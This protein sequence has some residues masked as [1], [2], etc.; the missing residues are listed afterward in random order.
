MNR[1]ARLKK[2]Y[3]AEQRFKLYGAIS[4]LTALFFVG[5]LLFKVFSG[6]ATAFIKTTIAV[7]VDYSR[8][9]LGFETSQTPSIDDLKQADFYNVTYQAATSFYKFSNDAEEKFIRAL[10][11]ARYEREIKNYLFNNP[12]VLGK[13]E[14]LYLTTSDDVDQL[15]KGNFPR[16]IPEERRRINNFQLQVYDALVEQGKIKTKFNNYFFTNGDSRDSEVAGIAGSMVGSFFSIIICLILAFPIAI[17]AAVYLEEFAP[18]NR[19]TEIIEINVNNLA[20]V[21]SIVFGLLALGILLNTFGLPRSTSLV[22]GIT[23]SLMTLPTIIIA[24]RASLKAVPPSIREAALAVGASKVQTTFHHVVPLAMPGTLSGTII[25]LAQALGET[26]PLL[27]IGMV[28]FVVDVP[29]VPTDPSAS[30]PVQI[31]LWSEQAE[32]GFVEKTS[33]TIMLLIGFLIIM[34]SLA[35]WAR[36][37]FERKWM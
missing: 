16:D 21:P 13:K 4:I 36:Q 33:A 20:A 5:L 8:E 32:R 3:T 37:K 6:G 28:A 26:A 27:L 22:G 25:G 31:Y 9:L 1:E 23:L 10:L 30:L 11:G 14:I 2:R 17:L 18:K 34:N 24:C 15:H 29:S 7:E 19:I 35:V 12:D